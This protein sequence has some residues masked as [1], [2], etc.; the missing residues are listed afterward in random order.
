MKKKGETDRPFTA[1]GRTPQHVPIVVM[2]LR[3]KTY[4]VLYQFTS[5]GTRLLFASGSSLR[6]GGSGTGRLLALRFTGLTMSQLKS[7]H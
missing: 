7:G 2:G 6:A 5:R 1:S 4:T 3:S